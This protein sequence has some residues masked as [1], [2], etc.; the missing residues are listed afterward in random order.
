MGK[1]R[2]F[3]DFKVM[4]ARFDS[5]TVVVTRKGVADAWCHL[6]LLRSWLGRQGPSW[7]HTKSKVVSTCPQTGGEKT[8]PC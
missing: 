8:K 6:K 7:V 3:N 4:L 2:C 1:G 5:R